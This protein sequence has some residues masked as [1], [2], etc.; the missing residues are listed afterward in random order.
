LKGCDFLDE[1]I[2][3]TENLSIHFGA[4]KAVNNVNISI[5][6]NKFTT[7]LGPNGAGKT[8]LFNLISGLLKAT[9]GKVFYKN[10]DITDFTPQQRIHAG[11]GRS[12]QLT[13]VFPALS[14]RENIRL[15][16]QSAENISF[17]RLIRSYKS[18]KKINHE[19]DLILE[20]ILLMDK[21]SV[22]AVDL[23]HGE[24]RKLE[25]GM[26]LAQRPEVLLLDEPTA[27]MSIEEVP[28]MI[29]LLQAVK[30]KGDTTIVLIEHK[31]GM[32]KTLSDTLIVLV[33]GELLCEGDPEAVAQNPEVMEAYLGGGV[34][35]VAT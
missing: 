9:S 16:V 12:F 24:Q 10:K 14:A 29:E 18:Y 3:K 22:R 26:V 33:N 6:K 21:A 8:T 11:I 23:T 27:G 13:N 35:N 7:I 28:T 31:M 15:S 19:T 30:D 1:V 32:V 20:N 5:V 25:L 34:V 2:L 4:L 17:A